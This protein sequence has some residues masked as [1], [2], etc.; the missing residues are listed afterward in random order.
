MKNVIFFLNI[1][2]GVCISKALIYFYCYEPLCSVVWFFWGVV[3]ALVFW[4]FSL[5][6]GIVLFFFCSIKKWQCKQRNNL[7]P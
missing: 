3:V 2:G 1:Y 4:V 5:G 7:L 6:E